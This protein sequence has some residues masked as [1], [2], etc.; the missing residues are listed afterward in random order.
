MGD[1]SPFILKGLEENQSWNLFSKIASRERLENVH[2]N[3][4]GIGK[5]IATMCKG[6]PLII[7]TL[8]TMLQ[9]ES[10]ERN[11]L[12]IKNNENLLSLQDENYNVL[13]VLKLSYDNLPTHLRQCFSYCALFPKDYEI[14]KKL[15]VQLWIAQDYIQSSNEN[16]HLEDVGDRYFKELWSRSLF[17]EVERDVVNDIVSCKMHDLIHDLAQSII[18]SEVLILKDN[19][20]NI[21]EKVRHILL[22]EQVSLMIG[23]LKE[24]PIRTFLKL[25]EDD[26]KNDSIVNSLIPSLKCLRMLSLDSFSIRKVPKY[27][28]KLSHL[29]YLDLSYNDFEVLPNAI[30]RLKN[31]QILKLNDCCKLKEFPKFTKK[32]INLRHLENDRCDNLTHMP[33]GIGELTFLQSLPLFIVGNGREFSKKKELVA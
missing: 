11:W 3:I 14:K 7:K 5:E 8:G 25:Y 29:R 9:F 23:S 4:I 30:T 6:V 26:F 10:E 17:H 13:P 24:K 19:I 18:G 16:E 20:K 27:L 1:S 12:S 33:C 31:L 21:P 2:P 15:L 28:G 32:L 22:F